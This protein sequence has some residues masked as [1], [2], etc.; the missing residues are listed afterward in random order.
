M[1]RN[2]RGSVILL[3]TAIIWGFAFVAQSGG[4][5]NLGPLTFQAMRMLLAAAFLIPAALITNKIKKKRNPDAKTLSTEEKR[6]H[7]KKLFLS[8][9]LCGVLLFL[10]AGVQQVGILYTSVGHA[11]FITALYILIVPIFGM[12]FFKR[13]ITARHWFCVAVALAGMYLLCIT[14][15]GF[16]M[17]SGDILILIC[18]F[19]FSFHIITIDKITGEF[20]GLQISAIQISVAAVLSVIFMFILGEKPTFED[21]LTA[22]KPLSYAG[23]LS[24][25][26]AYT[27]QII[28][29]KYT[30]PTTAA[31]IMSFESVFAVLG[32]AM[33]LSE[34]LHAAEIIGCVMMFVAIIV[35]QLPNHPPLK[36]SEKSHNHR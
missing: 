32:G 8:G 34:K 5:H 6:K 17:T 11:G 12:I 9:S 35:S 23:I 27:L 21:I 10:A 26:V 24:C 25:G 33:I 20:D 28:G 14:E 30:H 16:R 3:I 1:S 13:K 7:T 22:W 36:I 4:M 31:I 19:I 2:I 18:A 15:E 29:Q